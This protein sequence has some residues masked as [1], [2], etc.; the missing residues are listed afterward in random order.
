MWLPR[1]LIKSSWSSYGPAAK[2]ESASRIL[3]RAFSLMSRWLFD[4]LIDVGLEQRN[5]DL[6]QGGFP[7]FSREFPLQ[8][9]FEP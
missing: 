8:K 1:I 3:P 6:P 5:A 4:N 9:V 2:C 7:L